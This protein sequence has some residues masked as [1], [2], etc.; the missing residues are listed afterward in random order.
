MKRISLL[1]ASLTAIVL[2]SCG[3]NDNSISSAEDVSYPTKANV[4]TKTALSSATDYATALSSSSKSET[5]NKS[6]GVVITTSGLTANSNEYTF[7]TFS[8]LP[9]SAVI[10]KVELYTGTMTYNGAVTTNYWQIRKGSVDYTR[11][12]NDINISAGGLTIPIT[13]FNGQTARD[14]YYV[15]FNG[16]CVG[17]GGASFCSKLYNN[18]RLII[19]YTY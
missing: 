7:A 3:L 17:F 2:L 4:L 16:T 18:V 10:T 1:L 5:A 6:I 14:T 11:I 12:Y 19:Y 13:Y 8:T 9:T 15:L